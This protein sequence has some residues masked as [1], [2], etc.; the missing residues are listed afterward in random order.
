LR[1][2]SS[3]PWSDPKDPLVPSDPFPPFVCGAGPFKASIYDEGVFG[4]I[5][6][7]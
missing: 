7:D 2:G 5:G 6:F 1:A 3:M 4:C